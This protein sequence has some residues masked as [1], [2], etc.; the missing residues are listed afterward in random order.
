MAI[1]NHELSGSARR[2]ICSKQS[3]PEITRL[4]RAGDEQ[5][6]QGAQTGLFAERK[7]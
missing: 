6:P 2:S 3:W 5:A 1:T 4:A 7:D